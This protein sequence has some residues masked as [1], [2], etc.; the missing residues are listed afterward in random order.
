M[1]ENKLAQTTQPVHEIIARRWSPRA[2]DP[3]RTVSQADV[4]ALL[5]AA[6]PSISM[7]SARQLLFTP[8][9]HGGR[10]P[11]RPFQCRFPAC[12][13]CAQAQS[14]SATHRSDQIDL[15]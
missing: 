2:I 15:F 9:F 12:V 11:A 5:E 6:R 3:D 14:R 4:S 8:S 1:S 7:L 10:A 13:P